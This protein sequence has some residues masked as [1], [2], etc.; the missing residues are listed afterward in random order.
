[1][2]LLR[3]LTTSAVMG[4]EVI[5]QAEAWQAYDRWFEDTRVVFLDEPT[6]LESAFRSHS[7][8]KN[9]SPKDWADAYLIAFAAVLGLTLV[10]F[11]RGLL[12]KSKD[13]QLLTPGKP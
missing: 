2:S 7:Q 6:G 4:D 1:M 11:D 3:L 5:N 10:S 9:R 13:V 8:R 12:G